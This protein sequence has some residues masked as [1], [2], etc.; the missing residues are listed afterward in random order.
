MTRGLRL[1][2]SVNFLGEF[3]TRSCLP[4]TRPRLSQPRLSQLY[5]AS[6]GHRPSAEQRRAHAERFSWK[7]A[8]GRHVE[9]YRQGLY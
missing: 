1:G 8:A 4:S 6:R 9:L 3:V 5:Q 7:A 2:E